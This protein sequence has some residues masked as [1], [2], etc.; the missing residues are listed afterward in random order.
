MVQFLQVII[1]TFKVKINIED[2]ENKYVHIIGNGT[3]INPIRNASNAHTV[4]WQGNAW[5]QGSVTSNGADYAEY[6]E[7][8]DGNPNNE[9]RVATLVSLVNG[10]KIKLAEAGDRILGIISG[11]AA[12]LG[13]NYECEWNGKYLTDTYGRIQYEEVEEFH[14]EVTGED[15]NGNPITEKKSLGF[16]KHPI[17]N[18]DYDPTQTY[19]RR[20]DRPEWDAVG[21]VGK[22]YLK[23]NGTCQVG[24]YATVSSNTPGIAMHSEIE[25][26]MI[27]LKR[28][29]E[30]TI[31]VLL[32]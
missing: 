26:N 22:L 16:F 7:W 13:D 15:E 14:D 30:E 2:T 19:I 28:I 32:K 31:R 5:Y 18:P 4:D 23:D 25:T 21:L 10:D 17:L 20:S 11:T 1:S 9:D 12:V 6:F 27:V 8:L 24:Q 29:N 3:A